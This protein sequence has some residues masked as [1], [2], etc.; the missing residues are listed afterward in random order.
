MIRIMFYDNILDFSFNKKYRYG[1][2][3][4][5]SIDMYHLKLYNHVLRSD[6]L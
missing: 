1:L 2:K 6:K 3:K 4:I 5:K